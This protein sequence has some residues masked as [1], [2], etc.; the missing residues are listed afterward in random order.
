MPFPPWQEPCL[1]GNTVIFMEQQSL[2]TFIST[3]AFELGFAAVGFA[4]VEPMDP[5]PLRTWLEAGY[6]AEMHFLRRH[7]PLRADLTAVLPGARSVICGAMPYAGPA[8]GESLLGAVA[9]YARG[10]DYH[11]VVTER[12][13]WLW[14]EIKAMVPAAEGRVF[15]DSGPLPER[16]LARRAGLGW[17]GRHSCLL[18]PQLGSRFVLGEILTT[19]ALP[20][21]TP[22]AGDCGSCRRCLDACPT[23]ALR[24]PGVVDARRCLSYLSIEH[25]GALPR[26][27]RPQ[28]GTRLFGCDAC[29]DACPYNQHLPVYSTPLAPRA[30]Q[31]A[32]DLP[33]LL[34]LSVEEFAARFRHSPLK[35]AKRTGLL[36]NACVALG[37]LAA[38]MHREALRAALHD[39]EPVIRAHAAW[40]LGRLGDGEAL[41]WALSE[42]TDID[43]RAEIILAAGE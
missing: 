26:E 19:L 34:A 4:V 39:D 13:R 6:G 28:L 35:R 33:T 29:Q 42:E 23:G 30:E 17:V 31:L 5:S 41:R 8:P 40:A 3:R 18:H 15:V 32:C 14:A 38:P 16:E 10:E 1:P 12:L 24:E 2:C 43:V 11:R 25:H 37:N 21:S 7:L 22:L 20:P 27:V 36:R 9:C